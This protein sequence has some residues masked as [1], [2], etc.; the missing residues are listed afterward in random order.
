MRDEWGTDLWNGEMDVF[1]AGER[2]NDTF[3]EDADRLEDAAG[4]A[5]SGADVSAGLCAG[6]TG[7][8]WVSVFLLVPVLV[9]NFDGW[10]AG[11]GLQE[12]EVLGHPATLVPNR[13]SIGDFDPSSAHHY[14]D[15]LHCRYIP[16]RDGV[17]VLLR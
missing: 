12:G 16:K 11:V 8:S 1:W 14:R 6:Y 15:S 9:G 4:A 13:Q 3:D 5:V 17:D 2:A 7:V 10:V